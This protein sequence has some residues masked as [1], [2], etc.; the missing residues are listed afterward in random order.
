MTAAEPDASDDDGGDPPPSLES[1]SPMSVKEITS[2]IN[3]MKNATCSL[4]PMP[5]SLVKRHLKILAPFITRIVNAS[6]CSGSVPRAL[7]MAIVEPRLKKNGLDAD[8]PRNY[9]PVSNLAFIGKVIERAV[10]TQ[11][12]AHITQH[13]LHDPS[14]SAYRPLHSTETA[15]LKVQ[16][17]I[18][19]A[20]DQKR[21]VL[22]VML[23]LTAAFDTV[24]HEKLLSALYRRIGL[25]GSAHQW[26]ASYLK[27]R[28]QS[29][30]VK[31]T[32]SSPTLLNC[33]VPQGSVLGPVLFTI[34]TGPLGDI[35]R[36]HGINVHMYADDAQLYVPFDQTDAPRTVC[37]KLEACIR[38]FKEWMTNNFL[39]LNDSKTELI[40]FASKHSAINPEDYCVEV[41]STAIRPSS[42]V[43]NLGVTLD[44]HLTMKEFV[45]KTCQS[46]YLYLR[47]ISS[48]R[49]SLNTDA[50][51]QLVHS[52]VAS[53]ID[54]CNAL[55]LGCTQQLISKLQRVLN[56]AARVVL[57]RRCHQFTD[58]KAMLHHLHWLPVAERIKF[59]ML[60]MA[61]KA[62]HDL[63][64]PYLCELLHVYQPTRLLRRGSAMMLSFAERRPRTQ[65]GSRCFK[66]AAP[67][68]WN[69]L[70]SECRESRTVTDFKSKLKTQLFI[71]AFN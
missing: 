34:Y 3:S 36:R 48:I 59:K 35:A 40:C 14:Q 29:V 19:D 47:D 11:M 45:A 38:D 30:H 46:C 9:R 37:A 22:M 27:D 2:I 7:K 69:Q 50:A 60:L 12:N 13:Q 52:L 15:L 33:G 70:I 67:T 64:P 10:C 8:D 65:L 54:Y 31:E 71:T 42:S 62:Q 66:E 25:R 68:L 44:Q 41:G 16:G 4:D 32:S 56:M 51:T 18:L 24:S 55:I 57:S 6:L 26:V 63:A 5:T 23:D 53:R 1:F 28:Y 21:G 17:D 58:S 20:M 61:F 43:K 39:Q 49:N